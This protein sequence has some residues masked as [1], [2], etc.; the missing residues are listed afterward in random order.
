M[1]TWYVD[2]MMIY[3]T[4]KL[5]HHCARRCLSHYGDVIMGTIASQITEPHHCLLIHLFR[6]GSKKTSKF[7]VTGLCAGNSPVTGEF[8]AQKASNAEKVSI[9]WRHHGTWR[10][11]FVDQMSSLKTTN[12]VPWN[13]MAFLCVNS[14]R[15]SVKCCFC[16]SINDSRTTS[17]TG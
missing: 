17:A 4:P 2:M 14:R 11:P 5:G 6:H 3:T 10:C 12:N 13:I 9:W 16:L 15:T 1:N 7:R 8:P